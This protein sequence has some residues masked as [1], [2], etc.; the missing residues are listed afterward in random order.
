MFSSDVSADESHSQSSTSSTKHAV[1]EKK[2]H[3]G[4]R[5][6]YDGNM[7]VDGGSGSSGNFVRLYLALVNFGRLA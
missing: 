1:R 3:H 4:N 6:D 7:S 2:Q 5:R